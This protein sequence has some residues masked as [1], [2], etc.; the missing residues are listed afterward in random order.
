MS[1][2]EGSQFH[3]GELVR[4]I[5]L[6][7][8]GHVRT[9]QYAREKTGIIERYCGRFENPEE[10]AYGRGKST[11]VELYRV[12]LNQGHLWPDYTGRQ[13]DTLEI[14]IY[15]HWLRRENERGAT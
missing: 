9:P 5:D 13:T 3:A 10:R 11:S 4:I 15:G 1:G 7:K 14:E 6:D 12:R 8:P 2:K